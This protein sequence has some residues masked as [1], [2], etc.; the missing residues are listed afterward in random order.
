MRD[1]KCR[2]RDR[3]SRVLK[4]L[5]NEKATDTYGI[6]GKFLKYGGKATKHL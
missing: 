2:N 4:V 3:G 1:G 6:I 5:K